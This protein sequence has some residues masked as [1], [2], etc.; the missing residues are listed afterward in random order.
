MFFISFTW[1]CAQTTTPEKFPPLLS[2]PRKECL[3]TQWDLLSFYNLSITVW[4]TCDSSIWSLTRVK[5]WII[6]YTG[7]PQ[8]TR[9]ATLTPNLLKAPAQQPSVIINQ[10]TCR[11]CWRCE[12]TQMEIQQ[13]QPLSQWRGQRDSYRCINTGTFTKITKNTCSHSPLVVSVRIVW[14]YLPWFW[15]ISF[16]DFCHCH[17]TM[18]MNWILMDICK[19]LSASLLDLHSTASL[20]STHSSTEG[21]Y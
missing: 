19:T 12:T 17:N 16:W 21:C 6:L 9:G 5:W 3:R 4:Q 20:F 1:S 7:F 18:E 2:A 10:S 13:E 8:Y 15:V 14:F 11:I